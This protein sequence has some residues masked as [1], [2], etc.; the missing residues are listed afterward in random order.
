MAWSIGLTYY[1]EILNTLSQRL[2]SVWSHLLWLQDSAEKQGGAA[3][4][5]APC[6]P[7]PSR[8]LLIIRNDQPT[9]PGMFLSFDSILSS[10]PN[11]TSG[12]QRPMT[13][14]SMVSSSRPTSAQSHP[15]SDKNSGSGKRRWGMLKQILPFTNFSRSSNLRLPVGDIPPSSIMSSDTTAAGAQSGPPRSATYSPAKAVTYRSHSFKFS[16]EWFENGNIPTKDRKLSPPQLP[17]PAQLFLESSG[18][19]SQDSTP[20]EPKGDAL[21]PSKYAGRALAE[22]AQLIGECHNFFERRKIEGVP[23]NSKV[24]TPTLTVEPFR[25]PG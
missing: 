10:S 14:D 4:S 6:S 25:R 23:D 2:N 16:L 1:S 20:Q 9:S 21:G 5:T 11:H 8:C 7:A 19:I 24:E 17:S 13:E 15:L 3:P 22:W 12:L 18:S